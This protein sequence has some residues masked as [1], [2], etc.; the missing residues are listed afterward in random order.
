MDNI[1][2]YYLMPH[3]PEI[4]DEIADGNMKRLK[5][6]SE[7]CDQIGREIGESKPETIIIL[8]SHGNLKDNS[9]TI[10]MGDYIY[11]NFNEFKNVD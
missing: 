10:S 11:G 9:L 2:G 7:A 5:R 1:L 4:I 8:S 3:I 6:T